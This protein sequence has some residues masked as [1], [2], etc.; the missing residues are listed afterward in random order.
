MKKIK[1]CLAV[2]TLALCLN[3]PSLLTNSAVASNSHSSTTTVSQAAVPEQRPAYTAVLGQ[4]QSLEAQIAIGVTLGVAAAVIG[5]ATGG[6]G[7]IA[8]GA[9]AGF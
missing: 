9:L 4:G 7:A 2:A 5:I 1:A 6:A 8:A 3:A